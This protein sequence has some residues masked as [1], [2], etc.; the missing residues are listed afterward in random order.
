MIAGSR[1]ELVGRLRRHIPRGGRAARI[2]EPAAGIL[3]TYRGSLGPTLRFVRHHGLTV[4]AG[5]FRGL[6]YPRSAILHVPGLPTRLAGSYEAELHQAVEELIGTAPP[7]VVNIGAG[8]GYYA[9]GLALRCPQARVIAF[10]ADPYNA[11]LLRELARRNGVAERVEIRGTCTV[12]ELAELDPP[13]GTAV[14]SDC[15]GAEAE[16][17]DPRRVEWLARTP[18]LVEVHVSFVPDLAETLEARLRDN[19]EVESIPIAKRY[20]EDHEMFWSTP[21]TSAIQQEMLMSELRPWRTP[22]LWAVPRG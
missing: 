3:T 7:L 5:P 21:R 2:F 16:L 12:A 20:L 4:G 17:I 15:E 19:H 9:V 22:W 14:I 8:E 10:E 11:R 13:A 1:F 6:S 18:L